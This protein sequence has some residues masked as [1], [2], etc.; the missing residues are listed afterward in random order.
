MDLHRNL[1]Q[2]LDR[3]LG[4]S[5]ELVLLAVLLL[6]LLLLR[7]FRVTKISLIMGKK[8]NKG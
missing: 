7:L 6:L 8:F 5:V 2:D 4:I 3:I 1:H